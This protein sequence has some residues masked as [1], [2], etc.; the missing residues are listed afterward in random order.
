M[1]RASET[2]QKHGTRDRK[3]QIEGL[4]EVQRDD[5]M[6][7]KENKELNKVVGF[8]VN[9]LKEAGAL[10]T[11]CTF[12]HLCTWRQLGALGALDALYA[13][14]ALEARLAKITESPEILKNSTKSYL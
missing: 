8:Q 2:K 1:H 12:C 7:F 11:S 9:K 10:C 4:V 6:Q 14:D 3:K 13:L 5:I